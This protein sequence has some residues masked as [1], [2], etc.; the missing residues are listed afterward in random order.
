[1]TLSQ[2]QYAPLVVV[3][4]STGQQ[5]GSVIQELIISDRPYRLRGLTRDPTKPA[6]KSLEAQGVHMVQVNLQAENVD[7]IRKAFEGA[8]IIFAVTNYWEHQSKVR[9]INDGKALV[10]AAKH[11]N[12]KLLVWSGLSSVTDCSG[13]KYTKVEHFDSKAIVTAY[14][15][16]TGVPTADVQA[17]FYA[18]NFSTTG[19]KMINKGPDGSLFILF[20]VDPETLMPIIYLSK[21]FGM[22]VRKAIEDATQGAG[23]TIHTSSELLSVKDICAQF[24]EVTGKK[25]N[26]NQSSPDE[27]ASILQ[28][29]GASAEIAALMKEIY[30]AVEEYGYYGRGV[31][32]EAEKEGLARPTTTWKEYVKT[33]DWSSLF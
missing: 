25:L 10:D 19:L 16:E 27:F 32:L 14:A 17:G 31:D 1:M 28:A 8:D 4:G 24:E 12:A 26:H 18:E 21:D 6:A 9:D 11:V 5:G 29:T 33:T 3:C 2:E 13:G 15:R 20:P 7:A 23:A 30:Q 22:F